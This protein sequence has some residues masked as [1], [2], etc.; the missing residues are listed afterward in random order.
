MSQRATPDRSKQAKGVTGAPSEE[1]TGEMWAE[2]LRA[3]RAGHALR[4][5]IVAGQEWPYLLG[6]EGERTAV[7]LHGSD[8]D[9]ESLFSL[10]T[11]LERACRVLAPTY[12]AG[13][14]DI[15]SLVD[16]L[17][18]LLVALDFERT[19]VIGYSLGGYVAQSLAW[20]HPELVASLALLNTGAPAS[21]AVRAESLQMALLDLTPA[22]LVRAGAGVG[23]AWALRLESPG[24]DRSVAGFWRGYLAAMARRVGKARMRDHGRLVIDFL[25][26]T[27]PKAVAVGQGTQPAVLIADSGGDRTINP[28][29]RR[30]LYALYP[31]AARATLPHAGHLSVFTQPES[32]LKVIAAAF[33]MPLATI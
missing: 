23:A 14:T 29:E 26:A 3:F 9:G 31:S 27:A 24:L 17:A 7:L 20:R 10:M 16:G 8:S 32:Y 1:A 4:S 15:T 30:A 6:G 28:A 13:V 2:R 33:R 5:L 25:R 11:P 21:E 12:P 22:S 18:A 19:L